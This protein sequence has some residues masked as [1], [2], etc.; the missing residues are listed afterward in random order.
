MTLLTRLVAPALFLALSA[1]AFAGEA[2]T[3]DVEIVQVVELFTSQ[4]CSS[5]PPSNALVNDWS[6]HRS[7]LTLTYSVDYWDYLGWKDT[8]ADPKFSSRQRA[9]SK[10]LGHGRVY[11]PQM[12]INGERDKFR[13][14]HAQIKDVTLPG[15]DFGMSLR[16]GVLHLEASESFS[17]QASLELVTYLP[18]QHTVAVERGENGGHDL[19]L[20]NV[21]T[22]FKDLG[23]YTGGSLSFA[24]PEIPKNHE[25][26]ILIH[27]GDLGPI[28][29]AARLP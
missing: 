9:Y 2:K 7:I 26:A 18:G 6:A 5:C 1:P 12:V 4:G 27:D 20:T 15:T 28:L 13:Y 25:A 19:T 14:A 16:D 29:S 3:D 8:F 21:V 17:G 10:A 23:L 24:L 22:D 11:T